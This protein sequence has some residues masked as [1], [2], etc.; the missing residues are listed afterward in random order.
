MA[1]TKAEIEEL[2]QWLRQE[3]IDSIA[4]ERPVV[5]STSRLHGGEVEVVLGGETRLSERTKKAYADRAQKA[6]RREAAEA[7]RVAALPRGRFH[8][9]RKAAV[10]RRAA[11]ERWTTNP[12]R[13]LIW[14][15]GYWNIPQEEWDRAIGWLWKK[16]NPLH[17]TVRRG[18]GAGT[19]DNPYTIYNIK[20]HHDKKGIVYDG[21]DQEFY[22]LT[23]PNALDLELAHEGGELFDKKSKYFLH[24]GNFTKEMLS[25]SLNNW[26]IQKFLH[27]SSGPLERGR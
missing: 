2:E 1:L 3:S 18:W 24:L 11:E 7:R 14:T 20:I 15:R 16:Y 19:K 26:F 4:L 6:A 17:L 25:K 10:K 9:K 27:G 8:H 22:D 13:C 12:L 21:R 23:R 5:P